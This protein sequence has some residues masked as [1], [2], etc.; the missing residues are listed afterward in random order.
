MKE[1]DIFMHRLDNSTLQD[2]K[3]I[4]RLNAVLVLTL[5]GFSMENWQPEYNIYMEFW[6]IL[7][8]KNQSWRTYQI[9]TYYKAAIIR[10]VWN[11]HKNKQMDWWNRVQNR[12]MNI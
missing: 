1:Y 11:W 8:E 6:R 12:P 4:Y 3:L 5:I 10:Q 2:T 7:K 9:L